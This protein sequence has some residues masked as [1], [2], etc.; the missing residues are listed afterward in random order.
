M[1]SD[2]PVFKKSRWGTNRYTYNP[3]NPIGMALIILTL[4]VTLFALVAM[5]N[6]WGPFAPD[7]GPTWNP[8]TSPY[9][10]PAPPTAPPPA[11]W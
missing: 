10:P 5:E 3:N 1:N 6:R 11:T 4:A 7:P 2:E 9:D 8:P